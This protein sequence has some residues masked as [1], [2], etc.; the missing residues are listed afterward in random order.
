MPTIHRAAFAAAVVVALFTT[1]TATAATPRP[2]AIPPAAAALLADISADSMRGNLSFLASDALEGRDTPSRG[3]DVA[4]E[5]IAAQF[6]RAGLEPLGDDGYFQTADWSAIDPERNRDAAADSTGPVKVRNVVGVLRGS[7]PVL[8]KT[9]VLVTAHYDHL[10]MR[11]GNGDQLF[12]GANDDGSGTVSVIELANAFA[13]QK[14][15]PKRSI[16]FMTVFGEEHGLV[17][18]RYY[19]AHPLVPIADTV[20]DINLEQ[21]GRTDDSEGPQVRAAAV[22]GFDYSDVGTR[23]R[24]AGDMTGVRITKHPVNSDRYFA[25]SDNQALADLGVPAHTISVAYEYPDYHGAADTWDKID[26]PNMAAIDRTVALAVWTIANDAEVPHWNAANAKAA[27]YL[28]A[29][30]QLRAK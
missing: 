5:Y 24:T 18:S 13:A 26:Y 30:N 11:N 21:V 19:G 2:A 17:G 9:Y 14:V 3:L 10:G 6:R 29:A 8:A 28:Q 15:R 16:V 27:R 1:Y 23:L 12:N 7:D 4:A 25:Y 20:A 22:T